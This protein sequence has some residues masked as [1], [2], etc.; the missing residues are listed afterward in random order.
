MEELI[1]MAKNVSK[2]LE[3]NQFADFR[4]P[5]KRFGEEIIIPERMTDEEAI[6]QIYRAHQE[7]EKIIAMHQRIRAFPTDGAFAFLKALQRKFGWT[8]P[9]PTPG[10]FG[11]T[12]PTMVSIEIDYG[13]TAQVIWGRFAIPAL[14]GAFLSTAQERDP[15]DGRYYFVISGEVKKKFEKTILELADDVRRIVA[16]ESIYRGKAFTLTVNDKNQIDTQDP[17]FINLADISGLDLVFSDD[18]YTQINTSLFTPVEYTATCRSAGIPL[19]RGVLLAGPYG[20]GK[21]LTAFV[22]AKKCVENGW[23]YIGLDRVTGL[24]DALMIAR[25]M[26]SPVVVFAEDIDRALQGQDRTLSMDE[27]LNTI[28]GVELKNSEILTVL[29]TNHAS[30]INQA[31][32]RPGRLDAVITVTPPDAKA[33]QELIRLYAGAQ[34]ARGE[35]LTEVGDLMAGQIPAVVREVVERSK[36]YAI[37]RVG[38]SEDLQLTSEDLKQSASGM[39]AHLELLAERKPTQSNADKLQ[40]SLGKAVSEHLQGNGLFDD[41]DM[42]SDIKEIHDTVV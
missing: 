19:K 22:L 17:R 21:T 41:T 42:A 37:S 33:V 27:I 1:T 24:K 14:E 32:L 7:S 5:I 23:T 34:L 9:V 39:K 3:K 20:T 18:V 2:A 29:T 26:D 4:S 31:M 28:D 8:E 16:T 15:K 30:R 11:D 40:E 36:L 10:F 38:N 6:N 25:D 12:P 13:T 35:D